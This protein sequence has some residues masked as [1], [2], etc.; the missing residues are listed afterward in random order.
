MK[1]KSVFMKEEADAWYERNK[2][3]IN[4]K[5]LSND[6]IFI[7]LQNIGNPRIQL[8]SATLAYAA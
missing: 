3:C 4:K 5:S 6:P 2:F 7:A 8:R 1:Q